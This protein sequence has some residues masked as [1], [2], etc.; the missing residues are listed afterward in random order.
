[1]N[2]MPTLNFHTL[3]E[4]AYKAELV[5]FVKPL[6]S[7]L[8]S[9]RPLT[10]TKARHLKPHWDGGTN[11]AIGYGFDLFVHEFA[12]IRQRLSAVGVTFTD[13]DAA[14]LQ[15]RLEEIKG[16]SIVFISQHR[17]DREEISQFMNE[18]GLELGQL[19]ALPNVVTAENLLKLELESDEPGLDALLASRGVP[20]IPPSKERVVLASMFFNQPD[21]IGKD[22]SGALK[23]GNRAEAWFE[24]RYRSNADGQHAS[25]RY[26]ESDLF[27]LYDGPTG[28][29]T[30]VDE[31]IQV[32]RMFRRHQNDIE[33]YEGS[34]QPTIG[35]VSQQISPAFGFLITN[36]GLGESLQQVYVALDVLTAGDAIQGTEKTDLLLGASG[37]DILIGG[38]GDDVLRGGAGKDLYV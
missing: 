32:V 14:R 24:I 28:F 11:L 31:A 35:P 38:K 7:L 34:F 9:G 8:L 3:A 25:R 26:Q 36:L 37:H 29:P 4:I 19:L 18:R 16:R 33:T 20:T 6:E 2:A 13:Q 15:G 10:D 12:T 1:M 27:S 21:L 17:G 23:D 5:G 22:L 30:S